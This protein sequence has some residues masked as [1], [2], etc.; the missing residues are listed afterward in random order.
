MTYSLT[1]YTASSTYGRL[2]QVVDGDTYY[3]GFGNLLDLQNNSN[4]Q[5]DGGSANSV[6][7]SIQHVDGGNA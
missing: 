6:Y 4:I 2:V 1:G 3:D 7:T 5:L